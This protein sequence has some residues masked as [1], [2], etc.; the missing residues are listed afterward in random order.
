MQFQGHDWGAEVPKPSPPHPHPEFSVPLEVVCRRHLFLAQA[1][2]VIVG[3]NY[4]PAAPLGLVRASVEKAR[5]PV[6]RCFLPSPIFRTQTA[7][8]VDTSHDG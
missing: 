1:T 7:P 8:T 6:S 3:S 2:S 5:L 4:S